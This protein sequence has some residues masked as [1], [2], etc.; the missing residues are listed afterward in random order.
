MG[1]PQTERRAEKG[2]HGRSARGLRHHRWRGDHVRDGPPGQAG[3]RC[4]PRRLRR[5]P[6]PGYRH[7]GQP[8]RH[9]FHAAHGGHRGADVRG[10]EDPRLVLQ[11]RGPR[12][13]EG[14]ADRAHD[15]PADPAAVPEGLALRD[16]ARRHPALRRPRPPTA[17]ATPLPPPAGSPPPPCARPAS[18][19]RRRSATCPGCPGRR[20]APARRT[21]HARRS[22]AGRAAGCR[23][24]STSRRGPWRPR[25]S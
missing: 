22:R 5:H 17:S 7:R 9:R 8:A 12:G 15:R 3:L 24:R 4:R 23:R 19:C 18:G 13:R 10:R 2:I 1:P 20:P 11:A 6:R 16:P 25:P 21:A 14:H